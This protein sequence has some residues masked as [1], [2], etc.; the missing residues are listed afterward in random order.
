[1]ERTE[2]SARIKRAGGVFHRTVIKICLL[3]EV[4]DDNNIHEKIT[5]F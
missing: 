2:E 3:E 5:Q 4:K 1:M